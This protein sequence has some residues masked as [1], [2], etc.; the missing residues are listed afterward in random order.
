[1]LS[2]AET[3]APAQEAQTPDVVQSKKRGRKPLSPEQ[4]I[5]SHQKSLEKRRAN[6][7][8]HK[9]PKIEKVKKERL[10]KPKKEKVKKPEKTLDEIASSEIEKQIYYKNYYI[11]NPE[12]YTTVAPEINYANACIYK[13]Y[14]PLCKK[15]YIGATTIPLETKLIYFISK[16]NQFKDK[17]KFHQYLYEQGKLSWQ[18]EPVFKVQLKSLTEM[19][20]LELIYISSYQEQLL[21]KSRKFCMESLRETMLLFPI[22]YLPLRCQIFLR[23]MNKY[24]IK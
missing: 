22:N 10:I 2:D 1:M 20:Q 8:I 21:N 7:A 11:N 14:S 3:Q 6:A 12:R 9:K 24:M 17:G 16:L 4:K 18:I 5:A 15:F 23:R 13:I 19:N